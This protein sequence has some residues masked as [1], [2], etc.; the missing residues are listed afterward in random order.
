MSNSFL[1]R[2]ASLHEFMAEVVT[3]KRAIGSRVWII[4]CRRS[5]HLCFGH[6]GSDLFLVGNSVGVL[7]V[8]CRNACE[9]AGTLA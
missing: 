1:R 8:T 9:K 2:V 6:P 4:T 3:I 7:P 5:A